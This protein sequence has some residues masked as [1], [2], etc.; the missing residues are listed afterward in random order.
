MESGGSWRRKMTCILGQVQDRDK[1]YSHV[2][3]CAFSKR[4]KMKNSKNV[5]RHRQK[6]T[7]KWKKIRKKVV[8]G[9]S[10]KFTTFAAACVREVLKWSDFFIFFNDFFDGTKT[11]GGGATTSNSKVTSYTRNKMVSKSRPRQL[12]VRN[13][14]MHYQDFALL[15]IYALCYDLWDRSNRITQF[16]GCDQTFKPPCVFSSPFTTLATTK[17]NSSI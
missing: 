4:K 14:G 7:K 3:H 6:K 12:Q 9:V 2:L 13:T 5:K 16:S 8:D 17:A 11:F 15:G 10:V 1:K